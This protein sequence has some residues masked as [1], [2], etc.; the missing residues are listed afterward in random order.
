MKVAIDARLIGGTSTGDSTYWTCFLQALL[1]KHPDVELVCISNQEK[2]K[3]VPYI[4]NITW[5]FVPARSSRWWSMVAFPLAARKLGAQILHGQYGISPLAKNGVSTIHDVSFM[6]NPT[7]FTKRDEA[8]LR[9]G[10]QITS[11]SAKRLITV[12]ETSKDEILR[13]F[14]SA[15]GKTFVALNAC[16]PW[17]KKAPTENVLR[18]I[19]IES[20]YLLTVGTNW[21]RK[22]MKLALD[23][24]LTAANELNLKLVITGKQGADLKADHI[25]STGYVDTETL[26]A[27]YSG[28]KLFLAPSLHE[29]FGITLLEAMRCETPVLCGPGGAMP[30]VTGTAGFVMQD[31]DPVTWATAIGKLLRDPSK[32]NELRT[33]GIGREK[34][35]TWAQ[36]AEAHYNVYREML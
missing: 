7:W 12:S 11:K 6:V 15:K 28:S 21:A 33:K 34:E 22:N 35:F 36:S 5:H 26:S 29:G 32:L 13:Y 1:E 2:P 14:P 9:T 27:L 18:R 23:S 3:N 30:E 4:N 24:T 8:L 19:G 17:I 16:P 31:Y 20:D 25:V 10:V